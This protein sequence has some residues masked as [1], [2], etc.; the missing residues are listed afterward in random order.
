MSSPSLC[1][2]F[3]AQLYTGVPR[4]MRGGKKFKNYE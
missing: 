3:F 2:N 1:F 4:K